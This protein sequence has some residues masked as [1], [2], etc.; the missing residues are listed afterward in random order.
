MLIKKY[1]YLLGCII[2][3]FLVS[4]STTKGPEPKPIPKFA[5]D[6][7]V[8]VKWIDNDIATSPAYQFV[9]VL[10]ENTL[11]TA[12][13]SGNLFRI[14][15]TDGTVINYHRLSRGLSSGT[16]VS[17]DSIFVTTDD[18][19]LLSVSKATGNLKWQAQ[20]PTISI[21]APQVGG[22]VVVVKTNNAELLAYDVH[23]GKLLWVYQKH[24]PLLTLRANNTF[25]VVG[26]EVVLFG[27]PNGRLALI[28]LANGN[29]IWE[30]YVAIPEGATDLDK[31][32]D[33]AMRPVINDKLICVATFNGKITCLDAVSSNILWSKKFSSNSGIIIDE[34]HVY[35]ISTDGI[36]YAFDK[37]SGS[38]VW[39]N[40]ILQYRT[41]SVPVF[42]DNH[43]LTI[44]N[45]GYISLLNTND[46]KLVASLASNLR[47]GVSYPW[48]DGKKVFAQSANGYI[49]E[50]VK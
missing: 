41:L 42:L 48:S 27:Q 2:A 49:A 25:Q 22:D 7:M 47:D 18:G 14:D 10:E 9:P 20:L 39:K 17:S 34:H 32:T 3:A 35:S 19:Y 8:T 40:D 43:I 15:P 4:C 26:R 44:D 38:I 24:N 11:F 28:N 29:T 33:I 21:E 30:N 13:G 50:I 37:N 23:T 36:V 46:G 45:E 5:N 31:L 12:D 1:N 6:K 16:A